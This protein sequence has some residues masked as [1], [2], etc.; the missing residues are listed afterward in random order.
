M[1]AVF[2]GVVVA[3]VIFLI[4]R[5]FWCWYWKINKMIEEMEKTNKLLTSIYYNQTDNKQIL[6]TQSTNTEVN[7]QAW[8][9]DI[10][11]L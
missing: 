2:W 5:E 10:P 7:K 3:V 9:N 8:S 1:G 4:T 6:N 11:D